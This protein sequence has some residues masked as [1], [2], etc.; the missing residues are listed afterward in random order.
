VDAP[1]SMSVSAVGVDREEVLDVLWLPG[2][3]GPGLFSWICAMS[4]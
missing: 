1:F 4:N 3:V 2:F